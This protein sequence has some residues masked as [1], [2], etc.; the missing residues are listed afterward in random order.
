M[1]ICDQCKK[2]IKRW[3]DKTQHYLYT[4]ETYKG[5]IMQMIT[6]KLKP[7]KVIPL[8]KKCDISWRL[9]H[10]KKFRKDFYNA[11]M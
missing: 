2:P 10:E 5:K 1:K 8:H 7:D 4:P 11:L 6:G 3:R 9:E